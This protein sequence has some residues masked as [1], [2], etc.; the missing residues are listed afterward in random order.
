MT[1]NTAKRPEFVDNL[2]KGLSFLSF[3]F[4]VMSLSCLG[5]EYDF[6]MKLMGM[7]ALVFGLM[8]CPLLHL[9]RMQGEVLRRN[10]SHWF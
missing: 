5:V 9:L 7:V 3:D 10:S 1:S 6:G 4:D 8:L 2:L